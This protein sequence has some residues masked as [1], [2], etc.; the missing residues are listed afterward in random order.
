[1]ETITSRDNRHIKELAALLAWKKQRD[2]SGLFAAEGLRLCMDAARSGIRLRAVFLTGEALERYPEAA[3]LAGAA[4]RAYRISG[5][6]AARISD[7]KTPQG[8]FCIAP[9]LD[10][11]P[12]AVK[13]RRSGHY[14]L[15]AS[16]QDPGNLGSIIRT[17]QALGLDGL[18]LD[19]GCPDLY[20]PK[21][22][23]ASMGGVFRLPILLCGGARDGIRLLRRE[24]VPVWAAAL[25]RDA[26]SAAGTDF[27]AGAA[28]VI[29]NEGSGLPDEVIACCDGCVKIPMTP[30]TQSLGAAMA[31]GILLWE[32]G[33]GRLSARTEET[34]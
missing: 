7:T 19:G 1:M 33:R 23:R 11:G 21:V 16:L 10:N 20:G 25:G 18:L 22:L 2:A 28:V 3:G 26:R 31:A 34:Q 24:G 17:A 5:E 27:S 4:E 8:V 6:L 12:G 13:I 9:K 14:L 15:A 32:M 30:G 29:G